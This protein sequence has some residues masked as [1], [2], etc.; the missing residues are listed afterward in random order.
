M[1]SSS[2]TDMILNRAYKIPPLPS[3]KLRTNEVAKNEIEISISI[4][5]MYLT[6][7]GKI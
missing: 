6:Y 7:S 1:D 4:S 5:S 3:L 2:S